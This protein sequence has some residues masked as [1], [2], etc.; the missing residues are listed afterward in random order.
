MQNTFEKIC[1]KHIKTQWWD[2][3]SDQ[4]IWPTHKDG[5]IF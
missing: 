4:T 1:N 5:W 3:S 2:T